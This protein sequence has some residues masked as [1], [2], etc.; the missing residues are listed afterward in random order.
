M[1]WPTTAWYNDATSN[2][3]FAALH[4]LAIV[5]AYRYGGAAEPVRGRFDPYVRQP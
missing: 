1:R 4:P 2:P 3:A 5:I